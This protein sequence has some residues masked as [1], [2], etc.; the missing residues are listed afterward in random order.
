MRAVIFDMDGLL[1]DSEPLWRR[2]E[3]EVFAEVGL[4]LTDADCE[5]TTG[6]RTDD[7]VGFWFDLFPWSGPSQES[8]GA[9]INARAVELVEQH[10]VAM[11]G[12]VEAV[13]AARAAG[14][15]VGLATS[16]FDELIVTVIRKIG[17]RDAFEVTA[18]GTD[19]KAGKPDPA[20]YLTA[21]RKLGVDPRL[22]VAVEDSTVGVRAARAAAMRVIAVP[23]PHHFHLPGFGDADVKLR[24]LEEFSV[25]MLRKLA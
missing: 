6:L 20:V 11:P 8:V 5:R 12:A 10:G 9:A 23:A 13:E 4:H 21:A 15:A 16:S 3:R 18:S 19:E 1:I 22:C 2:A 7:L 25:E 14:F 24:S 17:L